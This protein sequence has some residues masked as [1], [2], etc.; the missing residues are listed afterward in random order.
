MNDVV[1]TSWVPRK[2]AVIF[3]DEDVD[4][5]MSATIVARRYLGNFQIKFVTARSLPDALQRFKRTLKKRIQKDENYVKE[6]DIFVVDVG[7]NRASIEDFAESAVYFRRLGIRVLYFDSHSNK[8]NGLTLL[9]KLEEAGVKTYLGQIGTAAA[10]VIQD[11]MGTEETVRLRKLGALSDREVSFNEMREM[12]PE[13]E[14]LRMLQAAVAWG[15]W[16]ERSFLHRIS[17]ELAHN[18]Q[19][20][21][22]KHQEII[23]YSNFANKHRDRLYRHVLKKSEILELSVNPRILAVFCL[24]RNDFGKARGTIAGHLAGEWSAVILLITHNETKQFYSISIRNHYRLKVDLE[25]LGQ[26][27]LAKSAGGS[28]DAYRITL[29]RDK[30][31]PFLVAIQQWAYSLKPPWVRKEKVVKKKKN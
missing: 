10:S 29:R 2:T 12:L 5:L 31:I 24:D 23:E 17:W 11:F 30:L 13:K 16:K 8:Y 3:A 4:G 21:F 15:A 7:I 22:T 27:A 20:D 9:P 6:L 28:K 19:L 26:L 1:S 18:V 25:R 14:G